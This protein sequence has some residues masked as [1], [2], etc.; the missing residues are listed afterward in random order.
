MK[1]YFSKRI[2]KYN[3]DN[4][5]IN[6]IAELSS[7]FNS[8]KYSAF[9]FL[10]KEARYGKQDVSLYDYLKN[11]YNE[12]DIYA[13]NSAMNEAKAALSSQLELKKLYVDNI[14]DKLNKVNKK[15]SN[16]NKWMTLYKAKS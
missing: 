5:I 14:K 11:N 12:L 15:Y 4:N 7:L 8:C 1:C 16:L 2:Y 13:R 6:Q 3:L 9:A 10:T